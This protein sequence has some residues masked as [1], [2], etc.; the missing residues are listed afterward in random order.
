[1]VID[2]F[3]A[4]VA[5]PVNLVLSV[6][7]CV[8][9]LYWLVVILGAVGID[10]LDLDFDAGDAD[11]DGDV[12]AHGF[13]GDTLEFLNV[14]RVPILVL[15]SVLLLSLWAIGVLAYPVFGGWGLLFQLLF[16]VPVLLVSLIVMKLVT[17]PIA[18]MVKTMEADSEAESNLKLLGRRCTVSSLTVDTRGGQVEVATAGAPL[19]LHART[20]DE[21]VV[22]NKGDEAV[23]VAEDD[24]SRVY[25]V[26][27]F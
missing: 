14:G 19:K 26:A 15:W 9:G 11:V 3:N 1:M 20:R 22:L 2:F 8:T 18:R 12:G 10:S 13:V 27:A 21:S 16:F 17:M 7:L 24:E 23:L 25:Y 6:L 4:C 5:S